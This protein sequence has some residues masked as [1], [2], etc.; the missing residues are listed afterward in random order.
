MKNKISIGYSQT[1]QDQAHRRRN[2]SYINSEGQKVTVNGRTEKL[3]TVGIK[4]TFRYSENKLRVKHGLEK[5]RAYYMKYIFGF[6]ILFCLLSCSNHT[7]RETKDG[8]LCK[9]II[10]PTGTLNETYQINLYENGTICTF[11]GTRDKNFDVRTERGETT[12]KVVVESI[13]KKMTGKIKHEE[14]AEIKQCL[15]RNEEKRC[16]HPEHMNNK[17]SWCVLIETHK[18]TFLH[19]LCD[20]DNNDVKHIY[21]QLKEKSPLHV[22]IHGW[23]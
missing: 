11:Y 5:R 14:L 16:F 15:L 7:K 19:G 21:N 23:S 9:C 22:N 2:R 10:F 8:L 12:E 17:D 4:G 3:E 13:K 6:F 1:T 18:S 20:F